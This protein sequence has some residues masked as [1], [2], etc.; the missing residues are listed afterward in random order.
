MT[1]KTKAKKTKRTSNIEKPL[2]HP[3]SKN[4][5]K[6][7]KRKKKYK[8]YSFQMN[9]KVL[10]GLQTS[11]YLLRY[12]ALNKDAKTLFICNGSIEISDKI[13]FFCSSDFLL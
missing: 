13:I 8:N 5:S 6:L 2:A 9:E 12:E 10:K 4:F 11:V 3:R 1:L 7:S